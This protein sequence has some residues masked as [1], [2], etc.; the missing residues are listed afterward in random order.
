M[1][2]LVRREIK[3]HLREN[4]AIRRARYS[5][6]QR[7]AR[8]LIV[9]RAL[10]TFLAAYFLLD[11]MFVGAEV[12]FNLRFIDA[13]PGWTTPEIKSLLKDVTSYFIAAQV[14]ILGIVSVAIGIVTLISQR[15][16]RSSSNTDIRLY[17]ME[18]L[19]YEVVLSGAALLIVLCVQLAWP[20]QLLAHLAHFGGQD[21]VFKAILT[22]FHLAW[23]LLN[24][25]VFAQFVLTT[26]R[27]VEPSARARL[28]ER[29]TAN[30][31]VPNDLWQ[32]LLS[33]FYANAP[34]ELVPEA[35]K[36]TRLLISFGHRMLTEGDVE[37]RTNFVTPSEL[38][39]VWLRPLNFVL[40]R[41]WRRVEPRLPPAR[42][43]SPFRGQ[44]VWLSF[45]P[46]FGSRLEG[47][48]AWCRRKDGSAFL[49]WERWLIR[50]C[51]RFRA[52]KHQSDKLPTPSN[53]L[54][55]LADRVIAQIESNA[56]T[57]FKGAFDELARFHVFLLDTHNTKTDQ[58]LPISL[59]E[60][61]GIWERPYSEWIRQYRRVF[62]SAVGKIDVETTFIDTLSHA[63]MRLLPGDAAELSPPVVTS[64]LD[65][66]IHEVIVLEA[67]VT[68]RTAIDVPADQSAQPRLQLAGSERRAY[69][70]VV[71]SFVGAWENVLRI[72]DTVYGLERR[73]RKPAA[74]LWKAFNQSMPFLDRHLRNSAYMLA[75]AI[76]NEDEVGAN[77]YRDSL[78]RWLDTLRPDAPAI[79]IL[80]THHALLMPN[81][82]SLDWPN[83]EARLQPYRRHAL[84][85][86]PPPQAVAAIILR[87]LY[88]DVLL[89]MSVVAL[90]WHVN[91]QQSSDIG[92]RAAAL[93][94][95]RQVIE[96][97]GARFAR[98]NP[99]PLTIFQSLFSLIIRA[100]IDKRDGESGY[101]ARLDELVR[102]LNGMS[103]R[104][105][106]PGRVYT[107]WGWRGLDQIRSEIL[108]VLV[109]N[110]PSTGDGG[111]VQW[112]RELASNEALF[113]DGDASLRSIDDS[114]KAYQRALMDQP[115]A[116]VFE[117]GT[118][119]LVPEADAAAGRDRL[120]LIFAEAIAAIHEQRTS[121]LRARSI[122]PAKWNV[123]AQAIS[124]VFKPEL[125]CFRDFRVEK[126]HEQATTIFEWRI[127]KVDKANFVTPSMAWEGLDNLNRVVAE[128]FSEHLT[129]CVW[130][131]FWRRQHDSYQVDDPENGFWDAVAQHAGRLGLPAT[132]VTAFEPF[133]AILS[134]W[135]YGLPGQRP[136]GHQ[137]E[138]IQGHPSGGGTGY[139]GTI[140]NVDVFT[141]SIEQGRSVLFPATMLDV[142]YYRLV[143]PVS[144]F[145]VEYEEGDNP[146]SGTVLVRFAQESVWHDK[147][148]IDLV[149]EDAPSDEEAPTAVE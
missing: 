80:L 9:G 89:I 82:L 136:A 111:I 87:R 40:R 71:F 62:E 1:R 129:S 51:F 95:R 146:W 102:F 56:I 39:D 140:D 118:R 117:R 18:S 113:V 106:V 134:Q 69:E 13:L 66:A 2:R 145:S 53:F 132:L 70:S 37:L 142:V 29:Y 148:I 96:G 45:E 88:D 50:R 75:S 44:E 5:I 108:A 72:A 30:V 55:E 125:Y 103:E 131:S 120:R 38:R 32:R 63:V 3:S 58:G 41:W 76:W 100:A 67:W 10:T 110:L 114:L 20:A 59:A 25:S 112:V 84:P 22:A 90:A 34:K 14:G 143:A 85:N 130:A 94:L 107:S 135:A 7:V 91:G 121:R 79:D 15:D 36:E 115:D 24:L 61:G 124:S 122:D 33:V 8:F 104:R 92:A 12:L 6:L 133:G 31:I 109:A 141:A 11:L 73:E 144:F 49:A 81:L 126:I 98:G 16:D 21:L 78:L 42:N 48:V 83:V 19:A 68:R 46:P 23:L 138:Y 52:S 137:V 65:L 64:L 99:R 26:L 47:E 147:P 60:I 105:V 17:Y 4:S 35:N 123:L 86:L 93:L 149:T 54:E 27:F 43:R 28:R 77:L 128:A 127:N 119:A 116:Q 139:I 57:S 101:G 97:E 74:E